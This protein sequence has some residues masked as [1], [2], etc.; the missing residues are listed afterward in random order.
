MKSYMLFFALMLS[1]GLVAAEAKKTP[2]L[3][4]KTKVVKVMLMKEKTYKLELIDYAA[5]YYADESLL[6][7]LQQSMKKQ[8]DVDLVVDAKTMTVTKCD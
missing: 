8:K 3:K 6:P 5:V 2:T 1:T 4:L 7:C